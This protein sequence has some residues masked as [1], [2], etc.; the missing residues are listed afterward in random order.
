MG[1]RGGGG[2]GGVK[3]SVS[4]VVS[5]WSVGCWRDQTIYSSFTFGYWASSYKPKYVNE[6]FCSRATI[7][8]DIWCGQLHLI[9]KYIEIMCIYLSI[10]WAC[11]N[12]T[13]I[14]ILFYVLYS[15]ESY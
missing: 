12:P 4:E 7:H 11:C 14:V 8:T 3:C 15:R 9:V 6:L 10:L 1:K 13:L 2:G 5:G